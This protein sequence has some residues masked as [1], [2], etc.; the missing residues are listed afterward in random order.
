MKFMSI[1][2]AVTAGSVLFSPTAS[3]AGEEPSRE[4]LVVTATRVE[5]PLSEVIGAVSIITRTDIE[6]RGAHSVQDLLRGETGLSIVNNGGLGKLS[7]VFLRGADSEQV[8]VLIDGVRVGSA[9]S[10]TTPFEFVPAP[11]SMARMRS[12]A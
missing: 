10:G 4:S 11:A 8:L 5:Q 9:T 1:G 7:N 2:V 6:R 12:A 3:S